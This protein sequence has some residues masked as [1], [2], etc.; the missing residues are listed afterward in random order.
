MPKR[1]LPGEQRHSCRH[2]DLSA[3]N[4]FVAHPL[5]GK[6]VDVRSFVLRT[7]TTHPIAAHVVDHDQ[8]DVRSAGLCLRCLSAVNGN[9]S[10][11]KYENADQNSFHDVTILTLLGIDD[12]RSSPMQITSR[13]VCAY[14]LPLAN[15]NEAR[16][17]VFPPGPRSLTATSESGESSF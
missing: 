14:S 13:I 8:N 11:K 17:Q 6:T 7:V 12:Y 1:I 4:R 16:L 9:N 10:E 2:T 3:P 15:D 5:L